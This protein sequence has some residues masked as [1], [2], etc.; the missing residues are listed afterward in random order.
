MSATFFL[1]APANFAKFR[2]QVV[3]NTS[4]D[5]IT[6]GSPGSAGPDAETR[7]YAITIAGN[8]GGS[9]ALEAGE[10]LRPENCP[11]CTPLYRALV[12][13]PN[14][15]HFTSS[16]FGTQITAVFDR[17]LFGN[18]ASV[19]LFNAFVAR[20]ATGPVVESMGGV[21]ATC[22]TSPKLPIASN[23]KQVAF[24]TGHPKIGDK[25]AHIVYVEINNQTS[26]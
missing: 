18:G 12:S 9:A 14:Q 20:G 19:W 25:S 5:G 15:L 17:S 13:S 1:A 6:P 24:P 23:F 21:C 3:F 22:F 2:Y 7:S 26:N 4:G 10:Y 11:T 8:T 16:G